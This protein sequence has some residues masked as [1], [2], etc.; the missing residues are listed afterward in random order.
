MLAGAGAVSGSLRLLWL[1]ALRQPGCPWWPQDKQV[2]GLAGRT[3][4]RSPWCTR[5]RSG[6]ESSNGKVLLEAKPKETRAGAGRGPRAPPGWCRPC[7]S[8]HQPE[9]SPCGAH[10]DGLC[11]SVPGRQ[12]CSGF[13]LSLQPWG[14]C[15]GAEASPEHGWSP[16]TLLACAVPGCPSLRPH[17]PLAPPAPAPLLRGWRRW[18]KVRWLALSSYK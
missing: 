18:S 5:E 14:V 3:R 6:A 2:P 9:C 4:S 10:R 15:D 13:P 1:R 7:F 16:R 17:P 8:R 11:S 12:L